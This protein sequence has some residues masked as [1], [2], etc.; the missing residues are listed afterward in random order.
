[1]VQLLSADSSAPPWDIAGYALHEKI[2]EGGT[3]EVYRATQLSL[4]R[5]VAV[6][7]LH[8]SLCGKSPL[9]DFHRESQLMASL[10]HPHV[11]AIYD[12]G[13][14]NGRHYLVMEYVPGTSLRAVMHSGRPW[15]IARAAAVLGAIAEALVVIHDRGILHLDL[16]P[17]NVLCGKE[18]AIKITD[19][20][21]AVP[22]VNARTLCELGLAQGSL[23]YCSPEQYHGLPLDQRSDIFSLAT[24]AYELLTGRLPMRVYKPASERNPLLPARPDGVLRRG[25]ARDPDERYASVADFHRDLQ[26]A[27]K[28]AAPPRRPQGAAAIFVWGARTFR[29]MLGH[30]PKSNS[31]F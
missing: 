31:G 13:Q 24:V 2:G 22:R 9:L 20:G 25:L 18:G 15:P 26:N 6:K 8:A 28:D 19:F 12:Y 23:D 3:G 14:Q 4:H 30:H 17:E 5:T 29:A 21:L 27:L 10:A 16:K 11:V 1:V 7:R